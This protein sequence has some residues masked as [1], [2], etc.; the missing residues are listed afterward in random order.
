MA[1][2]LTGT[3][4]LAQKEALYSKPVYLVEAVRDHPETGESILYL[5]TRT[6]EYV[7]GGNT[8]LD[9]IAPDGFDDVEMSIPPG[10][11]I[12]DKHDW[13]VRLVN[14]EDDP[15]GGLYSDM[16]DDYPLEND[17]LRYKLVFSTGSE[18]VADV[19]TL[20]VG[21]I[22]D[23]DPSTEAFQLRA[24]DS[25][26]ST[27]KSVPQEFPNAIEFNRIPINNT[28]RPL[29]WAFGALNVEP[30]NSA[31]A[32][33]RLA[34]C[35]CV[36]IIAQKYT[37]GRFNKDFGQ[38][39]VYYRT[40]QFYGRIVD[41]TQTGA[42]FTI[43]SSSRFSKILP[44]RPLS[45]NDVAAWDDVVDGATT[46]GAAIVSGDNL[47]LQMRG[48]PKLGTISD[49]EVRIEASGGYDYTVSKPGETDVTGSATGA[50]SVSLASWDFETNWDFE[51]IEVK[52][53]GTGNATINLVTLDITF[54][55]QESGDRLAFPVFQAVTGYE[56]LAS[57]YVDGD[58]INTSG[59]ALTSPI[60]VIQAWMRD[61]KT[62]MQM[63]IA[64]IETS[65][66]AAERAKLDGWKWDGS[67]TEPIG[68]DTISNICAMGK[69]RLFPTYDAKWKFSVFDKTTV[70]VAAFFDQWNIN[71]VNPDAPADEQET[72]MQVTRSELAELK[73]YIVVHYGWDEALN[74][75]TAT[76]IASPHY[77]VTGTATLDL[78][79]GTA[80]DSSGQFVT[81][82]VQPGYRLFMVRDQV[83]EVTAIVSEQV[84]GIE[85][86]EDGGVISDGHSE[87][88]YVGPNFDYRC[89]RSR[90]KYKVV[91]D[92][93]IESKVIQDDDTA[94]LLVDYLVEYWAERRFVCTFRTSLNAVDLE[95]TDFVL[96]DHPELPPKKRPA[97][98][99]TLSD[100]I[101]ESTD[102]LPMA[103]IGAYLAQEDDM[104][105]LKSA[106]GK[107]YREVTIATS[108]DEGD[109]KIYVDRAQV[110]TLARPWLAADEVHRAITKF[111]ITKI[112]H[113]GSG[114]EIEIETRET[115]RHYVPIARYAPEGTPDWENASPEERAM[116][117]FYTHFNGEV[118]WLD[119][120][121]DVARYAPEPA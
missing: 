71:V 29:P 117:A 31:G 103:G 32:R 72:S 2:D 68:R 110:G 102:H 60:D 1:K 74:E 3:N 111:E 27:L 100:A 20:F 85:P 39:Y 93:T 13:G 115:P 43:D 66:I 104:L 9:R 119:P 4:I 75:F 52:I 92:L 58:V 14:P 109:G 35:I 28:K 8:Y 98:L 45:S 95:K 21:L 96:I 82:G 42:F 107:L 24:K 25:S 30:W 40:A 113:L 33:P 63:E 41:Y 53:D 120:D 6:K 23:P 83:Y 64:K 65:N 59:L 79:A 44:I 77:T 5:G 61:R 16:L 57:R 62:G 76:K 80:T 55:E 78:T 50:K 54:L 18:T 97:Q 121:S 88:Y 38:P 34:P 116:Y 11:G 91:Q 15:D 48:S 56:D 7:L 49:I 73:N 47:D 106:A 17:E 89:F 37:S 108:V 69:I 101:S 19:L 46:T 67:L 12:A 118:V 99:G 81:E 70:P 114:T 105:V 26:R 94:D 112:K 87:T 22:Q 36:D 86:V 84:V 90:Q 51:Q 10:G